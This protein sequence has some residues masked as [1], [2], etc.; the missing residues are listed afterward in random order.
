M[1]YRA[2]FLLTVFIYSH[3]SFAEDNPALN[4]EVTLEPDD[5][6]PLIIEDGDK[7]N[8]TTS[9]DQIPA[10]FQEENQSSGDELTNECIQLK[11]EYDSLKGKPQRRWALKERYKMECQAYFDLHH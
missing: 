1:S 7:A 10:F 2:L 4:L 8:D 9:D 5:L 11:R 6:K 3:A